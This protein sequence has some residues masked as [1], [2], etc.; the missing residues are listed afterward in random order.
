MI[1][2]ASE[3]AVATIL[4]DRP[5]RRN[6]LAT[7]DW[8]SLA[9]VAAAVP[10]DAAVVVLAPAVPGVLCAGADLADLA[11]LA[12][13]APAR[14]AFRLAMRA[15]IEAVA[16]LPMPVVALAGQGCFG[17]GVALAL[18][19]DLVV[20]APDAR[21]AVP[22]ARLGI[23]YPAADVAR[24]SARVGR[25]AAARLLFAAETIGA[26]EAHRIGLVDRV[27][28]GAGLVAAIA[29][30][31]ACS[32]RDLKAMLADPADPSHD[33]AFDAAFARPAFAAATRRWSE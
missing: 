6:A 18:A 9:D 28:E 4:L 22:P 5:E 27:E 3:G 12:T 17:A 10:R 21:F 11:R 31:D 33:G 29:A 16:A 13:D 15:G 19:A 30:N 24:L 26:A 20:A 32:L 25:A 8:R 1:R 7:A 2:L 14:A 23:A